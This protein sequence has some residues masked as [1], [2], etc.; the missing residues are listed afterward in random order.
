MINQNI[1]CDT[2]IWCDNSCVDIAKTFD[3]YRRLSTGW[4]RERKKE[5]GNHKDYGSP[6]IIVNNREEKNGLLFTEAFTRKSDFKNNW[7]HSFG[8]SI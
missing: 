5:C 8:I 2:F 3:K 4:K 7:S 6:E 1:L